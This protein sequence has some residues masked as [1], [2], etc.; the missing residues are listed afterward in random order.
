MNDN[1]KALIMPD[2][3]G[4]SFWKDAINKYPKEEYPNLK[5]IFLGD[6]LD[7]YID[8]DKIS[9]E[10]AYDNFIEILNYANNDDRVILLIGNHDWHYF[11][12]LDTCRLDMKRY[13]KIKKL[14]IDN[15]HKFRLTY[16]TE[17]NNQ[18]YIFSHAG[19]T[20]TW[21][22]DISYLAQIRVKNMEISGINKADTLKYDKYLWTQKIEN[23]NTTYDFELF[24]Q[25]L[26]NYNDMYYNYYPSMISSYRGGRDRSGSLIWADVHEHL[27]FFREPL[28]GYYQI[29]GHT[30]SYP[31]YNPK[32]FYIDK[33]VAMLDA[34]CAFTLDET[35]KI[36]KI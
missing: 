15:L 16:Q 31:D 9:Q 27:D 18:K 6:Y 22:N 26:I 19:I 23:I 13:E 34:S 4:R 12:S 2:I 24:E 30:I 20:Q 14:F 32:A 17:I 29:F 8:Y 21:L 11:V 5:I 33:Y 35:G 25:C 36:E 1:I 7:P 28:P 10:T 3:H